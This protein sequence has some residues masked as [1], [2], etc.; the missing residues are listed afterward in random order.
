MKP[1][2]NFP[3]LPGKFWRIKY[4]SAGFYLTYGVVERNGDY[5]LLMDSLE[6]VLEINGPI[7]WTS[8]SVEADLE[9]LASSVAEL[10]LARATAKDKAEKYR[11]DYV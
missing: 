5:L 11:G 2:L 4:L 9:E 1:P 10:H 3:K 7:D 6:N 8:A